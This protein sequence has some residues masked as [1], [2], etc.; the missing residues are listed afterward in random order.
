MLRPFIFKVSSV[1]GYF[2]LYMADFT[3]YVG[4]LQVTTPITTHIVTPIATPIGLTTLGN[5][6]SKN[7][8]TTSS[9]R[10]NSTPRTIPK[11][12]TKAIPIVTIVAL[13]CHLVLNIEY[14][15]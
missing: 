10:P 4:E 2:P 7:I 6:F 8:A 12:T 13:L 14:S 5:L 15:V 3:M 9:T 1:L 11:P